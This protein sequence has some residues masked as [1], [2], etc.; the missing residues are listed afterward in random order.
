MQRISIS[1]GNAIITFEHED[2][3]K[4]TNLSDL[5]KSLGAYS[6]TGNPNELVIN[7]PTE[8]AIEKIHSL[9]FELGLI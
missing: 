3:H 1:Y 2:I 4:L 9:A 7:S 8:S 5:C 6:T